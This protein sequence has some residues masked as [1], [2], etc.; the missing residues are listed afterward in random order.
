ML[1]KNEVIILGGGCFWCTEAVFSELKGVVSVRPG[2]AGG[3][4]EQPTYE[5]VCSGRTGHA[6]VARVEY[7]PSVI[8]LA[9]ILHVF[10][11]THNPTTPN[12]QGADVGS[13]YRSAIYYTTEDQALEV[14]KVIAELEQEKVFDAPIITEVK[15]LTRFYEAENYH[16]EYYKNNPVQPYCQAV[17]NPKLAKFRA[18]YTNL[19]KNSL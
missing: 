19:L 18:K 13:Q 2:Y 6:E 5:Q 4:T 14:K 8:S 9:N 17:I 11:S 10:F 7:N 15:P 12:Q 16:R 1:V 3:T